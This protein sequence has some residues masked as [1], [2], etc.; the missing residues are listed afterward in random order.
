MK[1]VVILLLPVL[2]FCQ[3]IEENT[4]LFTRIEVDLNARTSIE[5]GN[6]HYIEIDGRQKLLKKIK[7]SVRNGKLVIEMERKRGFFNLF[8]SNNE[9][10]VQVRIVLKKLEY[11]KLNGS[12]KTDIDEFDTDETTIIINGANDLTTSG[13][14]DNFEMKIHGASDVILDELICKDFVLDVKGAGDLKISGETKN[15]EVEV[16]GAGDV[17]AYNFTTQSL[18]AK[19]MGAGDI[20]ITVTEEIIASIFGAGSITYKG[21]PTRIKDKIFGAGE[22][23][24]Y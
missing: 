13:R 5:F 19:I 10:E 14:I 1:L 7:H 4:E 16:K 22:I 18:D 8:N 15:F 20:R 17:K 12:G 23:E 3:R 2:L 21:N 11:L 6:K 9:D 24:Q